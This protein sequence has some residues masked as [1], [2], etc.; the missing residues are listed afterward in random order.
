M[1]RLLIDP[2]LAEMKTAIGL[3]EESRVLLFSTEGD[4]DR[5]R[6]REIMAV[7]QRMDAIGDGKDE[8]QL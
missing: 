4:T 6:Y 1:Q 5:G 7:V 3:T 2:A 8:K